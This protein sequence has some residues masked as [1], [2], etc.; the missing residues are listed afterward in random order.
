MVN[1]NF[2]RTEL[3]LGT[4]HMQKL[5]NAKVCIFGI[6]GVGGYV[7]EA[8]CRSGVGSFDLID[9]DTVTLSNINRQIIADTTTIGMYKVD[10][11]YNRVKTINPDCIVNTYKCFFLPE[12]KDDFDFTKY[13]YVIDCV[14]TVSAK[15]AIIEKA[16]KENVKVIS[17]MGTGNKLDPQ[18]FVCTDIY[19]TSIDPLA[20]V[21]R[22]ELKK[23]NIKKCKVVYSTEY[24]K[25]ID[26]SE[27]VKL[28]NS[29]KKSIPASNSYVPA[30]AGLLIASVVVNDLGEE[31]DK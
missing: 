17:S 4:K 14:D 20:R 10:A 2:S 16:T 8:L 30:S 15:I 13:D 7:L 18:K 24:P 29:N 31:D 23:R 25:K 28:E 27:I 6:G 5:K 12:N 21:M 3:L 1:D 11:A 22:Y 19:K 26:S 9:N